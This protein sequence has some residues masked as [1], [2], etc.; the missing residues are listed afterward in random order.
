MLLLLLYLSITFVYNESLPFLLYHGRCSKPGWLQIYKIVT[1]FFP[2]LTDTTYWAYT[3]IICTIGSEV[4]CNAPIGSIGGA[5]GCNTF[6]KVLRG[7]KNY[8]LEGL[9]FQWETEEVSLVLKAFKT[10]LSDA[11]ETMLNSTNSYLYIRSYWKVVHKRPLDERVGDQF[12]IDHKP[13]KIFFRIIFRSIIGSFHDD[14]CITWDLIYQL[15]FLVLHT[16][17]KPYLPCTI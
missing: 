8:P 12:I 7:E 15:K 17:S 5:Q 9:F 14:T 13:F 2:Y 1:V 3:R 6:S 4:T 11:T 10:S 16:W